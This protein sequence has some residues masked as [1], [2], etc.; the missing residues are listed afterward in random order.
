MREVL[1]RLLSPPQPGTLKSRAMTMAKATSDWLLLAF[2]VMLIANVCGVFN[3]APGSKTG[4]LM[5]A[6]AAFFS[7]RYVIWP[8]VSLLKKVVGPRAEDSRDI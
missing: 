3:P 6:L 1:Y 8:V 2:G 7:V 5:F 4:H